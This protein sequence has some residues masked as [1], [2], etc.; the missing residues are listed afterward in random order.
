MDSKVKDLEKQVA[1]LTTERDQLAARTDTS[2]AAKRVDELTAE[3]RGYKHRQAFDSLAL[4]S[5]AKPEALNDLWQLSKVEAKTDEPDAAALQ[6]VIDKQKT[7]RGWAFSVETPPPDP[8]APP[9]PKPAVG[10]GQGSQHKG[11]A[12]FSEAQL[13]DPRFVMAN[14]DRISAAA[15]ERVASGQL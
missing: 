15:S 14:F 5:G 13:S 6:T 11:A 7:D 12:Q 1:D 3:L 2:A 8:N 10:S 4:K 9:P